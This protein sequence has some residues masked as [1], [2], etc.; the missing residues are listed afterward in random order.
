MEKQER[1]MNKQRN[2]KW[3]TRN[4]KGITL[5]ALVITI[6]IIII[7]AT[8]TINMAFGDNGLI[9]Q[10]E[11]AKDMAANST[12]AEQEGMNS[13][14][15]EYANLMEE[16]S[17]INNYYFDVVL[18]KTEIVSL[19]DTITITTKNYEGENYTEKDLQYILS[20]SDPNLD[21]QISENTGILEGGSKQEKTHTI[22]INQKNDSVWRNSIDLNINF[23]I[24]TPYTDSKKVSL[25]VNAVKIPQGFHYVGD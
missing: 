9:K 12:I 16:D 22:T 14:M 4:Q 21:I 2:N 13:L 23:N 18:D 20:T 3:K 19:P 6:I 1:K 10:A 24:K 15:D 5:V 25:K 17:E 8:V 11:L 7:L